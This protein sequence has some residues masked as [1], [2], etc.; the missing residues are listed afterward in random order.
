VIA[1]ICGRSGLG[2]VQIEAIS[3]VFGYAP[4]EDRFCLTEQCQ[5]RLLEIG[6]RLTVDDIASGLVAIYVVERPESEY[7]DDPSTFGRVVALVRPLP[8]PPGKTI[9]DYPSGCQHLK[10]NSLVDRW[11]IGWPSAVE[12]FSNHGGPVLRH[13]VQTATGRSDYGTFVYPLLQGPIDLMR[14]GYAPIRHQLMREI[15][16][17]IARDPKTQIRPF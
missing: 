17:Q 3:P 15:R 1:A 7:N 2:S 8:M 5:A 13:V 9:K 10:G 12:F 16:H 14:T 11:P 6:R 4:T